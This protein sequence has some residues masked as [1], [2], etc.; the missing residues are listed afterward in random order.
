MERCADLGTP[1]TKVLAQAAEVLRRNR[2]QVW[3]RD[4]VTAAGRHSLL[5]LGI[6]TGGNFTLVLLYEIRS[7]SGKL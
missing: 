1:Q 4:T 7:G 2:G 3:W 5:Q 6:G